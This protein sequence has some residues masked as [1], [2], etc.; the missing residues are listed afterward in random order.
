[1]IRPPATDRHR[2]EDRPATRRFGGH[3]CSC[4]R[5]IC[6]VDRPVPPSV[7]CN[8]AHTQAHTRM[9]A[10]TRAGAHGQKRTAMRTVWTVPDG[11]SR[12]CSSPCKPMSL[13]QEASCRN[14][15]NKEK[16]RC[17][18]TR[19]VSSRTTDTRPPQDA[20]VASRH[21]SYSSLPDGG[22]FGPESSHR[23]RTS[24]ARRTR[25]VIVRHVSQDQVISGDGALRGP[26]N[27]G[28]APRA[29]SA[30][31]ACPRS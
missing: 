28:P 17:A 21:E 14:Q 30:R 13:Q 3:L 9:S 26:G 20:T 1:M 10:C 11:L 25:L 16:T 2:P 12:W 22:K 5:M 23:L 27:P 4:V 19:P 24:W 31:E 6:Y 15:S 8:I 18:Q 29:R 7:I